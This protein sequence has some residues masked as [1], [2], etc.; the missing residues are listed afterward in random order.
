MVK[1]EILVKKIFPTTYLNDHQL[2]SSSISDF[3]LAKYRRRECLCKVR[4]RNR[5][6]VGK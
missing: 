1:I 6:A 5:K 3:S 4:V 2:K